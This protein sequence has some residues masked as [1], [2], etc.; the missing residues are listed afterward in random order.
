MQDEHNA[1]IFYSHLAKSAPVQRAESSIAD[2]A[3]DCAR[4]VQVFGQILSTQFGS[5]FAPAEAEINTSLAFQD[6]LALAL[7]EENKS[8]RALVGLLDEV[9]NAESEKMIQRVINKKIVN[10]GLLARLS[11]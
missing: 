10:Y 8:M 4:Y 5:D 3:S 11:Q 2:I 9:S 7:E 6:A 1:Q